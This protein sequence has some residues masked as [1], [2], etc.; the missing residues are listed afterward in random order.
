[1]IDTNVDTFVGRRVNGQRHEERL[2]TL[3]VSLEMKTFIDSGEEV[4]KE[5]VNVSK[6]LVNVSKEQ[7]NKSRVRA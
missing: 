2:I 1:M 5:L 4:S 6:E 3:E 7:A